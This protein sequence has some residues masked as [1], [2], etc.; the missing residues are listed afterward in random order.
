MQT[1]DAASVHRAH[2]GH[3]LAACFF[4]RVCV[5]VCVCVCLSQVALSQCTAQQL[6]RLAAG[7]TRM[8]LCQP[9]PSLTHAWLAALHPHV[10]QVKGSSLQDPRLHV[11]VLQVRSLFTKSYKHTKGPLM[12]TGTATCCILSS[13]S[14]LQRRQ[15]PCVSACMQ[16]H[17]IACGKFQYSVW[18][19]V[20]VL[21]AW[22]V[23]PG[24]DWL[25]ALL[26]PRM[27][28][29][30]RKRQAPQLLMSLTE[31]LGDTLSPAD[32]EAVLGLAEQIQT[33]EKRDRCRESKGDRQSQG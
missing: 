7:L 32:R 3:G 29:V 9:R 18:C 13:E 24:T 25:S 17:E 21:T 23:W 15:A 19:V 4:I 22:R 5:C 10:T 6:V 14:Y 2:E 1:H 33:C 28:P 30:L 11:A 16:S 26:H 12:L 20:Q 8:G 27:W 31:S